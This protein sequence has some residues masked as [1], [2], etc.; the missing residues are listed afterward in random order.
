VWSSKRSAR[1]IRGETNIKVKKIG[2]CLGRGAE[3]MQ[4]QTTFRNTAAW[5]GGEG[6][7]RDAVQVKGLS[8]G[9]QMGGFVEVQCL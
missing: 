9:A 3:L 1:A 4:R 5:G 2:L 7:N 6:R 8:R